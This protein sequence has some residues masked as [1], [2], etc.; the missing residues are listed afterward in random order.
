MATV[1]LAEAEGSV[2]VVAGDEHVGELLA[3][4]LPAGVSVEF[5][6]CSTRAAVFALWHERS[7]E[8]EEGV[9]PWLINPLIVNRIRGSLGLLQRSVRF[10]PWSALL[11]AAAQAELA[12]AAAWLAANG[13]GRLV[14]RQFAPAD[15]APGQADLQRL[16]GQL[17]LGVLLRA[18]ADAARMTEEMAAATA[19]ADAERLDLLTEPAP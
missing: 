15:P 5:V 19:E 3:N 2:W 10:S 9:Q 6:A 4:E 7:A 1:V 8:A 16:R 12:G 13:G 17:A 14:L 18:G 11:D